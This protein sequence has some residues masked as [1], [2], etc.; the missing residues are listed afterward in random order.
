MA[1]YYGTTVSEGGKIKEGTEKKI[2]AIIEKYRFDGGDGEMTVGVSDGVLEVYGDCSCWAYLVADGD[3]ADED[4]FDSFLEEVMP[5]LAENLIVKEVGNEKC[6]YVN[7][8]A[9]IVLPEQ[10]KVL[11]VSLDEKIE[12]TIKENK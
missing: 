8:Y 3:E 11:S 9:Y 5:F 2:E 4:V 10:K 12:E 1:N 6:R 7:A